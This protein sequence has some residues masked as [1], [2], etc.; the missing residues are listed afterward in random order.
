MKLTRT[1]RGTYIPYR[2][3]FR[4]VFDLSAFVQPPATSHTSWRWIGPCVSTLERIQRDLVCVFISLNKKFEREN[5]ELIKLYF[6]SLASLFISFFPALARVND[7]LLVN[8]QY[9]IVHRVSMS[10]QGHSW[11]GGSLVQGKEIWPA[12][13][14]SGQ[15]RAAKR[16][17]PMGWASLENNDCLLTRSSVQ[18]KR[19][20][21]K[22]VE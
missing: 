9:A 13:I 18:L 10:A 7:L 12:S 6:M 17:E 20:D 11:R 21:C 4:H 15:I 8:L 19:Q 14:H 1:G 2:F 3:F 22:L 5:T 16:L